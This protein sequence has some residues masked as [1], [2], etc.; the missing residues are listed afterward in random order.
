[1]YYD[2]VEH[3]YQK[4]LPDTTYDNAKSLEAVMQLHQKYP[5][6]WLFADYYFQNVMTDPEVRNYIVRNW[7]FHYALSNQYVNVFSWDNSNPQ[8]NRGTM[9]EVLSPD[10]AGTDYYNFNLPPLHN[11]SLVFEVDVEG[12]HFNNELLI[13]INQ[14][15]LPVLLSNSSSQT[16]VGKRQF[17]LLDIPSNYLVNGDNKI[18]LFYNTNLTTKKNKKA[19]I[20]VY[21][22][23]FKFKM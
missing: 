23:T 11:M 1:M 9:L 4:F 17:F 20:A 3:K 10:Y 12:I 8:K 18:R 13:E 6:G 21:N 16:E 22:L 19:M 7:D 15:I 2:A 5:R 14:N